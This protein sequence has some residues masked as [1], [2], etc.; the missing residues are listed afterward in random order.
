MIKLIDILREWN[1]YDYKSWKRKNV[2]IRGMKDTTEHNNAGGR[3]GRGLYTAFLSNKQMAR[4]YGEVYFV[5]NA[6]PKK[7]K[8][9][10]DANQAEIFVQGLIIDFCKK[11]GE[12]YNPSFF[13]KRTSIE[14]EMQKLGYDGLIVKGREMVNYNPPS[15]VRYYRNENGLIDYY[16]YYIEKNESLGI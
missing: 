8:I 10:Q 6:I 4:Q 9:F 3:F 1:E 2:T 7:P 15:D 14:D 5:V 12:D 11:N 16:E 13:H